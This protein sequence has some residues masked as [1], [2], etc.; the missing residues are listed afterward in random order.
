MS[1]ERAPPG[2]E[3]GLRTPRPSAG[4]PQRA[5]CRILTGFPILPAVSFTTRAPQAWIR[6][7]SQG[8]LSSG[9]VPFPAM[10]S[11]HVI[12]IGA[13]GWTGLSEFAR[14]TVESADVVLGAPR[15]LAMLPDRL[16][17]SRV[18]WPS[19]LDG[20][21]ELVSGLDGDVVA[22]A[23]GDPLVAGIGTTLIGLLGPENVIVV[24]AVSSV[25]L[26][27]ARLGWSAETTE[28]LRDPAALSRHLAPKRRILLLSTDGST[29]S[30]VAQVLRN[31]GFEGTRM[32]VLAD[33]GAETE[34]VTT[35]TA[36]Q[37][38]G[39]APQLHVL[40]LECVGTTG[41]GLLAGLPD[42]SFE[43]DGQLT[44]RDLRASALARLAPQ[45]G[46][47]LWDVGA[48][49]GSIGIE[50]M[51]AHPTCRAIA[52][53]KSDQ[54]AARIARNATALGVPSL[55]I[56]VGAAPQGLTGLPLPDAIF[57]GGGVTTDGVIDACWS[58]LPAGGRLVAHAVTLESEAV[59]A[60]RHTSL[61]G[62]LIQLG[63]ATASGLGSFTA[64]TPNRTVTQWSITREANSGAS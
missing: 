17:Q 31:S 62:E 37:W 42:D 3:A 9:A 34:T 50:W 21:K 28:V 4:L 23:S 54:R 12:G 19:P 48:G 1:A 11:L 56:V 40:A 8:R 55:R 13:D 61:G 53:E 2:T 59:L 64:W 57:I 60:Q 32:T 15:Q 41:A 10:R 51:R 33:L 25:S 6:E 22:L 30:A 49:A 44:K 14:E 7:S 5:L 39:D 38:A 36:D 20:L 29:P 46:Q 18:T 16:N 27:R 45:P 35:T 47:L 26:A 24:P 43:N 52:V 58:A 63:T